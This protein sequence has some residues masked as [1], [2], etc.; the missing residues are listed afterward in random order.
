MTVVSS[1]LLRAFAFRSETKLLWQVGALRNLAL[2]GVVV[3]SLAL[4][5]GMNHVAPIRALF[6]LELLSW[7]E[8]LLV[9]GFSL[10]PVS[11]L[12]LGKL[13]GQMRAVIRRRGTPA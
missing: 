4:Q 5:V 12:E 1:G 6:G 8:L 7:P 11:V 3:G 13:F 9:A 10:I 2:A